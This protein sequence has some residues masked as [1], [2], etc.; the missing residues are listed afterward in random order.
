MSFN[1]APNVGTPRADCP[2]VEEG[3]GNGLSVTVDTFDNGG[4]ETGIEIRWQSQLLAFQHIE[5]DNPGSG[6]YLRKS[7]FVDAQVEV[8]PDGQVT[9]NYDGTIITA[10][11]PNW[12]P[13][14]GWNFEFAA[15]TGGASDNHYIDDV[16]INCFTLAPPNFTQ[17]PANQ[18]V[19]EG[20]TATFT[21]GVE[22]APPLTIQWYRDGVAVPGATGTSLNIPGT[23]ANSGTQVY[24]IAHNIFGDSQSSTATLSVTQPRGWS[25]PPW[26]AKTIS[27]TCS[28]PS[29]SR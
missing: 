7:Q 29:R 14:S 16:K 2:A 27:S 13:V 20:D 11:I 6:I 26:V 1:W 23:V 9:F 4:G 5:K 19:I 8:L 15:R 28:G 12:V 3:T 24:V 25:V 10:T 17:Q 18:T 21:V 22:G